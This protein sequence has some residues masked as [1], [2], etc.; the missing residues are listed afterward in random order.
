[1]PESSYPKLN[2]GQVAIMVHDD[3]LDCFG[4]LRKKFGLGKMVYLF[5]PDQNCNLGLMAPHYNATTFNFIMLNYTYDLLKL[6]F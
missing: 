6:L 4:L 2:V 1:M 3:K 5:D